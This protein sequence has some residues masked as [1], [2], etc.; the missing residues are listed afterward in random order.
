[1]KIKWFGQSCFLLTAGDGTKLLMDPF[2]SDSHLNYKQ[3]NEK[4][5]LVTVSHE[6]ADHNYTDALP[7][8]PEIIK[9]QVEKTIKGIRIKGIDVA[10]DDAGGKKLGV[11]TIFYAV[12]DG[13]RICHL[14]DLGHRLLEKQLDSIGEVDVLLIPVGSVFTI[15]VEAANAICE[16]IKPRIAIPMHYKTDRCQFLQWSAEDFAKGKSKV[17]RIE[18]SE[19]EITSNSLPSE[20]EVLVLQ[21]AD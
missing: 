11:N 3:V 20:F 5:D 13:I 1:M 10:H 8:K 4:V 14:G 12:I 16:D 6:H 19:V 17:R 21:Y 9:G 15:D 2:K 7:G 18:G